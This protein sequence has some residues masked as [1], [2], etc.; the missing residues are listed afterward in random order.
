[1]T[2]LYRKFSLVLMIFLIPTVH[3]HF[4]WWYDWF[5]LQ[6]FPSIQW[7]A[8]FLLYIFTFSNDRT[9]SYW[10]FSLVLIIC[11]ISTVHF[12]FYWWC[13][14][15]VLQIFNC[16]DDMPDSYCTFSLLLI[17]INDSYCKFSLLLM[18]SLIPTVHFLFY[19]WYDW[20]VLQIFPC[21]HDMPNCYCTF[22]LLLMIWRIRTANLPLYWW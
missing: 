13:D 8:W 5:V 3:F 10:K 21:T 17:D 2:D 14:W 16:T 11:L 7:Y 4:Y 22:S 12:H 1:M 18:I 9:D 6:I 19:W 15:F 20:F